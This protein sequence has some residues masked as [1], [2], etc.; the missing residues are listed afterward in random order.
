MAQQVK[1]LAAKPDDL[2]SILRVHLKV[3]LVYFSIAVIKYH[4]Q[5]NSQEEF[6]WGLIQRVRVHGLPV[7]E[8]QWVNRHGARA[9]SKSSQLELQAQGRERTGNE[10]L[11][12]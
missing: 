4:D 10:L 12:P 2:S 9:V 7:K 11:K 6:I 8:W 3:R 1:G 5:G